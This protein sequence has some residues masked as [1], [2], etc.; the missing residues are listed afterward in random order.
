MP[1]RPSRATIR[2]FPIV[3]PITQS[4]VYH[5]RP[6]FTGRSGSGSGG[7]ATT[8]VSLHSEPLSRRDLRAQRERVIDPHLLDLGVDAVI[9]HRLAQDLEAPLEVAAEDRRLRMRRR[10]SA[11]RCTSTSR[12]EEAAR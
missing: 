7:V 10:A 4:L 1:P 12:A 11:G 9:A 5:L 2:K 6:S 3:S 8:E